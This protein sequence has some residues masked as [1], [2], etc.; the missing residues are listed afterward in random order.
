MDEQRKAKFQALL[1]ETRDEIN[2]IE[3]RIEEELAAI[4]ERL[5]SLQNE[6]KAQLTIYAGYCQLLGA[7]NEFESEE[8]EDED[9]D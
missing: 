9:I 4:K 8:D 5:A 7:T 1:D 6:K 3:S 2:S